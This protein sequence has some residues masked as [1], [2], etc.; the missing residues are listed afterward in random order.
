MLNS[1]PP[2]PLIL[3]FSLIGIISMFLGCLYH[4]S[5]T[6]LRKIL[7]ETKLWGK[8]KLHLIACWPRAILFGLYNNEQC[9]DIIQPTTDWGKRI[10]HCWGKQQ[11]Q[12]RQFS[13]A[14]VL[15]YTSSI[16]YCRQRSLKVDK[17]MIEGSRGSITQSC[18]SFSTKHVSVMI[19][20]TQRGA[21]TLGSLAPSF[22]P[23]GLQTGATYCSTFFGIRHNYNRIIILL[24]IDFFLLFGRCSKIACV[25]VEKVWNCN[26]S[27]FCHTNTNIR[28]VETSWKKLKKRWT[29][30][31]K[32]LPSI[33][34]LILLVWCNPLVSKKSE[35]Q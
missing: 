7:D 20:W 3:S 16:S 34:F 19:S 18:W 15:S 32:I 11:S 13:N 26:I 29:L 5:T 12:L 8:N 25:L 21:L 33:H 31:Q 28:H 6:K 17:L 14:T 23:R 1:Y 24:I 9:P 22:V 30:G 10:F 27:K 35:M 4:F 2:W